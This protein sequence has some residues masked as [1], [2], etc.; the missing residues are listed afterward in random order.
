MSQPPT[1]A[2]EPEIHEHRQVAESF[3]AEAERY[4]RTRPP[5]PSALVQRDP[6]RGFQVRRLGQRGP[7]ATRSSPAP[8][9]NTGQRCQACISEGRKNFPAR[10]GKA[11]EAQVDKIKLAQLRRDHGWTQELLAGRAGLS[12]DLVRKLEQGAKR[13]AR[14]SSLAALARMLGVPVGVLLGESAAGQPAT[15][16]AG[17]AEADREPG[18]AG[19]PGPPTLL[20][21]LIAERRWQNFRAFEV[22]FRRAARDLAE[23]DGDPDLAQLAISSRQWERWYSGNVKTEPYPDACRVLE[24]MFG[25]PVQQLL[26]PADRQIEGHGEGVH[27]NDVRDLMAWVASSNTTDAQLN[28]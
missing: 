5:Y 3:G 9:Y 18:Q 8:R 19:V 7:G 27:A 6:G 1:P 15:G 25:Y 20:R 4:D 23:R 12:T 24:H 21:A 10:P 11:S 17:Q 26:S 16:S 13:S 2:R 14:L 28:R 22:Q